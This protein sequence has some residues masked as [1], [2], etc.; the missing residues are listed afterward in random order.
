MMRSVERH[1]ELTHLHFVVLGLVSTWEFGPPESLATE[2]GIDVEDVEAL[3]RDLEQLGW[4][5]RVPLQ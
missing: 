5:R 1:P 3:C 2:M 4:I